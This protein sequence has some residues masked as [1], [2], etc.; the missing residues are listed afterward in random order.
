MCYIYNLGV[1]H[2]IVYLVSLYQ[3]ITKVVSVLFLYILGV[4]H[5]FIYL[6]SLYIHISLV[7]I[8]GLFTLYYCSRSQK[9]SF[10]FIYPGSLSQVYILCIIVPGQLFYLHMEG[11]KV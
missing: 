1:Y 4:Y 10:I 11:Q 7:F 5:R 9:L 8:T 2:S 3:K 6:A